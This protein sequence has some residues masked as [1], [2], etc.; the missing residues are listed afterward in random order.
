M[1]FFETQCSTLQ[2]FYSEH[3]VPV[4]QNRPGFID[5][6]TATFWFTFL[7]TVC[8]IIKICLIKTTVTAICVVVS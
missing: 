5:D 2:Q 6:V 7:V 1:F 3:Y 8:V 4:N